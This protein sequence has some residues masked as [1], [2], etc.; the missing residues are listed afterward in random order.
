[1]SWKEEERRTLAYVC[2]WEEPRWN[3]E[4]IARRDEEGGGFQILRFTSPDSKGENEVKQAASRLHQVEK[5]VR[6][7]KRASA[8]MEGKDLENGGEAS[9]A[10]WFRES[11]WALQKVELMLDVLQ[12]KTHDLDLLRR[13]S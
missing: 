8:R 7:D 9:D 5:G 3:G 6:F 4:V 2:E 11:G 13:D 10:G 1:M 12:I